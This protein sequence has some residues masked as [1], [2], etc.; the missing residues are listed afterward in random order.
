MAS[1]TTSSLRYH[2]PRNALTSGAAWAARKSATRSTSSVD[3][4]SPWSELANEPAVAYGS[5][6]PSRIR[7]KVSATRRGSGRPSGAIGRPPPLR[8]TDGVGAEA[9]HGEPQ[10]QLL[11]VRPR[12]ALAQPGESEHARR[13]GQLHHA[14]RLLDRRHAGVAAEADRVDVG[15]CVGEV[16]RAGHRP[17]MRRGRQPGQVAWERVH[18]C[19]VGSNP[20][21]RVEFRGSIPDTWVTVYSEHIG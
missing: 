15:G 14:A 11:L 18:L 4:G 19:V 5:P 12:V 16:G 10:Q 6:S 2:S 7:A 1:R 20:A 3:R 17:N 21:W 9:K 8:R 13:A